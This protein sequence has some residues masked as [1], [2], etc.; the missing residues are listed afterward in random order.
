MLT[1]APV[2]GDLDSMTKVQ[3]EALGRQ[4]GIELDRRKGKKTLIDS[5][6]KAIKFS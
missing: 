1:E 5:V 2:A 6:K 4:N 3:L